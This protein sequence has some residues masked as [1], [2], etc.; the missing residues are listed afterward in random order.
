MHAPGLPPSVNALLALSA[1]EG[2]FTPS[3]AHEVQN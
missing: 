2:T 1:D 3:T